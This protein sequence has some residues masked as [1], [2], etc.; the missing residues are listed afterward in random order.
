MKYV[1]QL[2][3]YLREKNIWRI[4]MMYGIKNYTINSDN[5]ID[6]DGDVN[7]ENKNLVELPLKFNKASGDFDCSSNELSSLKGAPKYVGGSFHCDRNHLTSLKY[8]PQHINMH[9]NINY[10][11]IRSLEDMP[12]QVNGIFYCDGNNVEY[13]YK[14]FI[15]NVDN[16][17]LFNELKILKFNVIDIKRLKNYCKTY[18]IKEPSEKSIASFGYII[19]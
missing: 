7:L 8:S 1:K 9:F 12:K 11:F 16:I 2:K 13:I 4:C 6:V 18:N 15:R 5:S 19:E 14:Y 17:E 3:D 10:N